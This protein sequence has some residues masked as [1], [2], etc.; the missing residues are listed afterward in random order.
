MSTRPLRARVKAGDP[1]RSIPLVASLARRSGAEQLGGVAAP[2][3]RRVVVGTG[4]FLEREG[5]ARVIDGVSDVAIV[6]WPTSEE[7][8]LLALALERP[9]VLVVQVPIA[10]TYTDEGIR[11]AKRLRREY[12]A[13]GVVALG[14]R[15][16]R[17]DAVRFFG[18]SAR[19]RA[20]LI[21]EC[22][23][24]AEELLSAIR[25][26]ALGG[27]VI[28]PAIIDMLVGAPHA[29]ENPLALLTPRERDVLA[30]VAR[31]LSNA[32]IAEQFSLSKRAVEKHISAI[33][34]H[35]RLHAIPGVNHRVLATLMFLQE[36]ASA[37]D[38]FSR[39][40]ERRD[41]FKPLDP[42]D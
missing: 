32:A 21:E 40:D 34:S 6:G 22:P 3:V 9:D 41:I 11:I 12:P 4:S 29:S 27:V 24:S 8:T 5:I 39:Q 31:G 33:Y 30:L 28:E 2:G 42:E 35:L 1:S 13:I 19:G 23:S 10:P 16:H 15:M 26:V 7:E 36:E 14:S 37:D 18:E 25:E 20:Y 38:V 17:Q